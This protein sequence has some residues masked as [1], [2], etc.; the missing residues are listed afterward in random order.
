MFD[1]FDVWEVG[2]DREF[3]G[4][5]ATW[6][7]VVGAEDMMRATVQGSYFPGYIYWNNAFTFN[8]GSEVCLLDAPDGEVFVMQSFT[9]HW[10]ESLTKDNLAQLGSKLTLPDGWGF[11]AKVLD[12]D[13]RVAT[14]ESGHLAHVLQDNLHNTY[15]GSDAGKAFNYVP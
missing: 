10:D 7:G 11:R 2:E 5:K 8:Q 3:N 6:M 15:Q 4:I 1:E 14:V 13:L 9:A 12:R